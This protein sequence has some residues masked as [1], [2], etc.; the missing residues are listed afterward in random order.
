MREV[1]QAMKEGMTMTILE[2]LDPGP[3]GVV[4]E[5]IFERVAL[6]PRVYERVAYEYERGRRKVK[7]KGEGERRIHITKGDGP[8][9]ATAETRRFDGSG[10]AR[11]GG[12]MTVPPNFD[13][14]L[15]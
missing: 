10:M 5:N 11:N 9:R 3:Y 6:Y 15:Q 7:E 1:L 13:M 14:I 12:C 8:E 4:Y 2:G